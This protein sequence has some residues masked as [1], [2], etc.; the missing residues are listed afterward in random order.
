M[1]KKFK[2]QNS[3]QTQNKIRLKKMKRFNLYIRS[4]QVGPVLTKNS[5][6]DA[7]MVYLYSFSFVF[8]IYIFYIGK[9]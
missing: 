4:G 2:E 7:F 3:I 8:V 5:P 6:I 1:E 9:I